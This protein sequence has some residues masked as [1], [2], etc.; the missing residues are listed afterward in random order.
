[1]PRLTMCKTFILFAAVAC[2]AGGCASSD[3]H[4]RQP[5]AAVRQSLLT[6]TPL[7]SNLAD[8]RSV[9]V[10]HGWLLR[11]Q[12]APTRMFSNLGSFYTVKH[13]PWTTVKYA[14][15]RFDGRNRLQDVFV[16]SFIDAP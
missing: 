9:A 5:N 14:E 13:F 15:W 12:R 16:G 1:M 11:E 3:P 8:V 10:Q 7:G 2:F 6:Q 4:L